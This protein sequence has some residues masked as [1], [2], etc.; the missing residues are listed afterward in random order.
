MRFIIVLLIFILVGCDAYIGKFKNLGNNA[1]IKCWSGGLLI[2][3]GRS[4]GK[5]LSEKNS[6]GYFFKDVKDN[7]FKE[8]SGNCVIVYE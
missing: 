8:V 5:V 1:G 2:F 3:E 7:K 6:D 4:S